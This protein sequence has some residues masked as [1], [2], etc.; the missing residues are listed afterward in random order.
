[1]SQRRWGLRHAPTLKRALLSGATVKIV[2]G[3]VESG[4]TVWLCLEIYK[5][6]CTIPRC[7]DGVRR[8]RFLI[9]RSTEGE[10]E[11][12][13]MRTWKNI[14]PEGVYG[15][16]VGSMPAIHH[17]KFL[18]VEAEV[19]FFAFEDASEKVLKKLRSTEYTMIA[20]NEGQFTPQTLFNMARQRAGRYPLPG[21]SDGPLKPEDCPDFDRLKRVVMDMNAPRTNDHWVLYMRGDIALPDDMPEDEKRK[22]NKPDDWE[23]FMQP[24]AVRPVYGDKGVIKS[25]EIHP[26]IEN[27]PYQQ[28]DAILSMC[29]TGDLDD[30]KRDYM[31][32]RVV[33]KHGKPRY[34]T[35]RRQWNVAK[36][37][38]SPVPGAAPVIGYDPGLT[39]GATFWQ[40][41][42]NQ[43]RGIREMNARV[44]ETIRGAELQGKRM[45]KILQETFPWYRESGVVCWGDP[46]GGWG[47]IDE[48]TTYYTIISQLG[49]DFQPTAAKDNPTLRHQIGTK[50]IPAGDY[51][52]PRLLLCPI[53]CPTLIDAMDGGAVMRQIKRGDEMVL[54]SELVKNRHSDILESAEYAW[55]GGGEDYAIV[56]K[57][58]DSKPAVRHDALGRRSP[59]GQRDRR[60]SMRRA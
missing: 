26:E 10:L 30:I 47:T 6:M 59:F 39:G 16:P 45:L 9:I 50:L 8:S 17:L 48:T 57:P 18:D 31:N 38:I 5:L 15:S 22:Y 25:F 41:I 36:Q 14:F 60:W 4:K 1:M 23:F 56:E 53:G 20:F 46:F 43:W 12:G 11:R 40:K 54:H 55:W 21:D 7:V 3:P 37:K 52:E 33:V 42:N 2:Q 34:P 35:F 44:D 28:A 58:A 29:A 32:E 13:I 19:E 24:P 27:L 49:L 51:G